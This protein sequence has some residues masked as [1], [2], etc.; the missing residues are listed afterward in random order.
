MKTI[1]RLWK[2]FVNLFR[3]KLKT[4]DGGGKMELNFLL[5]AHQQFY[6]EAKAKLAEY[7]WLLETDTERKDR[8]LHTVQRDHSYR[9]MKKHEAIITKLKGM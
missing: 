9:T 7:E 1:K 6:E 4:I 8:M 5:I 2:W 3:H